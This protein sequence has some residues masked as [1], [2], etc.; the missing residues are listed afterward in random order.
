MSMF[1]ITTDDKRKS[2]AMNAMGYNV[3][4]SSGDVYVGRD[5]KREAAKQR[6]QMDSMNERSWGSELVGAAYGQL[7]GFTPE[8]IR[9]IRVGDIQV[10]AYG[11]P[12]MNDA[13]LTPVRPAGK[14]GG[15]LDP[16]VLT[17]G[18]AAFFNYGSSPKK[19]TKEDIEMMKMFG[20]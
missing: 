17:P 20:A 2:E 11:R 6:L 5:H 12:V 13:A 1:D 14:P 4:N 7:T 19:N 3:S 10:D 8:Q 18:Q 9:Q 16:Q 15:F